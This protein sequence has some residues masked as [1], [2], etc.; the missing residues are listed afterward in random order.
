MNQN[1]AVKATQGA[2][3]VTRV[4]AVLRIVGEYSSTGVATSRVSQEAG[5]NR[6]TTHRLLT[7]LYA[8]GFLDHDV[9]LARWYPGP[10]LYLLGSLAASRYDITDIARE[11]VRALASQTGESAFLSARR[12][13]ET[14]CLLREEG[15]FPIRS[16]VLHE[17]ARFPL[18]VVSAGLAILSYLPDGEIDSYL[19][20]AR[21]ETR[22]GPNHFATEIQ[23]RIALTRQ[24]GYSVNPGLIVE[25]SWGMAAVIFDEN[26]N[27]SWALTITGVE[28]RFRAERQAEL[29]ALLLEQAHLVSQKL[30]GHQRAPF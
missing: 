21:L 4:A 3:V 16:F 8:E 2:Q 19:G 1:V 10:E 14:V 22:F 18:G 26:D 5:L 27:P 29:G 11:S 30:R 23:K 24:S 13:S 28:H 6:S 15:S 17:G 7:S 12:G 25:G 9:R 20:N